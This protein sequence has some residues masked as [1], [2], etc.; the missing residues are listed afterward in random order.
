MKN[1]LLLFCFLVIVLSCETGEEAVDPDR[2]FSFYELS[3]DHNDDK[4]LARASLSL[5]GPEGDLVKLTG[6]AGIS[7]NGRDLVFNPENRIHFIEY[8]GRVDSGTFIYI[9]GDNNTFTNSTPK[10][11]EIALPPIERF[12]RDEDLLFRWIGDPVGEKETVMLTL[13]GSERSTTF[14]SS[15]PGSTEFVILASD[16]RTLDKY[17]SGVMKLQRN[18][19]SYMNAGNAIGGR[20][21]MRY[22]T[23]EFV[24]FGN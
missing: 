21:S 13:E 10:L 20:M 8:D 24:L 16:I 11:S 22:T 15:E 19:D 12:S 5:D 9:D 4:T 7:F 1:Y 18:Y 17:G 6:P 14:L 2:I 23:E 3:Y